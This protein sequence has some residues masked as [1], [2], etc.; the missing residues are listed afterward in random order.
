MDQFLGILVPIL[1]TPYVVNSIKVLL[2]S[3]FSIEWLCCYALW[4]S[5]YLQR[6]FQGIYI[7]FFLQ[8]VLIVLCSIIT[9]IPFILLSFL[10]RK[11]ITKD[12]FLYSYCR[13]T[14]N[15]IGLVS[16]IFVLFYF[17][18]ESIKYKFLKFTKIPISLLG[19]IIQ[20]RTFNKFVPLFPSADE[21]LILI[22]SFVFMEW[23]QFVDLAIRKITKKR[24]E[25]CY[26]SFKYLL[27][28]FIACAFAFSIS[29]RS[30]LSSIFGMFPFEYASFLLL[31][32]H[33]LINLFS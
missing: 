10:N 3:P 4:I 32:I 31:V 15:L 22:L 17:I 16:I 19:S 5:N 8:F 21:R 9:E 20:V 14:L 6:T 33:S 24:A 2:Y 11:Q 23:T 29:R 12:A 30:S 18:P 7:S 25:T 26:C 13:S 28:M 27:K 1:Q